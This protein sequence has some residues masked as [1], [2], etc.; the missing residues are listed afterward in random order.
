[1]P[2]IQYPVVYEDGLIGMGCKEDI[3]NK[4]SFLYVPYK[5][6]MSAGKAR[7]HPILS[8]MLSDHPE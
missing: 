4:E 8:K 1:M 6:F 2:K 5:L 3:E 7:K